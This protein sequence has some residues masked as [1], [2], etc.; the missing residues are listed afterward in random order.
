MYDQQYPR[1]SLISDACKIIVHS[2]SLS[3]G[4][5]SSSNAARWPDV[6]ATLAPLQGSGITIVNNS[7]SA[8]SIS[9]LGTAPSTMMGTAA[10]AVDNVLDPAKLNVLV[11][12]EGINELTQNG[13]N[14]AACLASYEAYFA[15]RRAAATAAGARLWIIVG[16]STPAQS[17]SLSNSQMIARNEAFKA[18]NAALRDNYRALGADDCCD[19]A[20]AEPF[21]TIFRNGDYSAAAF[22]AARVYTRSD[23][24]ADDNIHFGDAGYRITAHAF[25]HAFKRVR[26]R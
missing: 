20:G 16:T 15:A 3:Y 7:V 23:G 26:I 25:A 14:A 13:I 8:Q 21:D 22:R 6:A 4:V 18:V 17:A 2:N 12:W 5:G 10:A 19:V 11:A 9:T 1:A 24:A